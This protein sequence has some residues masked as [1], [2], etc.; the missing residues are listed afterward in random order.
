MFKSV[1]AIGILALASAAWAGNNVE[2]NCGVGSGSGNAAC[3]KPAAGNPGS[4]PGSNRSRNSNHNAAQGGRGGTATA[5]GGDAA[6]AGGA[7]GSAS[8]AGGQGVGS[9]NVTGD[10]VTHQAA[11]RPASSA[12]AP[13]MHTTVNCAM[14]GGLAVQGASFGISAGGG[15]INEACET[16]EMA[17]AMAD[18]G[19]IEAAQEVLC[20]LPKVRAARKRAGQPCAEDLQRAAGA[21]VSPE[22]RDPFVRR[23]LGLP[24]LN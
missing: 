17:K 24:P 20:E 15:Q 11:R 1:F 8:A 19:D 13:A 7:G 18:L 21:P 10:T 6:A 3:G 9:V 2:G 12:V 22:Y 4:V 14:G 16:I 5:T 23:R